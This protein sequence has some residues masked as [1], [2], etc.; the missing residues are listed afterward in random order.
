ME[1]S[2]AQYSARGS[3]QVRSR[4]ENNAHG[5]AP[6]SVLFFVHAKIFLVETKQ[7][8]NHEKATL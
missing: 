5:L 7:M 2:G 6:L 4:R 3:S 1:R 8:N